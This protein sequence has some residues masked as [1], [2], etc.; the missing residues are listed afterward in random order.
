MINNLLNENEALYNINNALYLNN[1]EPLNEPCSLDTDGTLIL[2]Q[3]VISDNLEYLQYP[4]LEN[5]FNFE[6]PN[7]QNL[8]KYKGVLWHPDLRAYA[9]TKGPHIWDKSLNKYNILGDGLWMQEPS[10]DNKKPSQWQQLSSTPVFLSNVIRDERESYFIE[11]TYYQVDSVDSKW[12][13]A[14]IG[15]DQLQD[16]GSGQIWKELARRGLIFSNKKATQKFRQMIAQYYSAAQGNPSKL[17]SMGRARPGW[18]EINLDG[19]QTLIYISA[20]FST[21]NNNNNIKYTGPNSMPWS[22]NGIE[23]DYLNRFTNMLVKNPIIAL[24][25]GFNA[26]GLL[27]YHMP[28]L[29]HNPIWALLGDSSIGKTLAA[30]TALSMRG[31][32]A[33]YLRNMDA[34]DNALK[35]R[36]RSF[37]HTGGAID[38]IGSGGDKNVKEKLANIYQWASGNARGRVRLNALT[39]EFDEKMENDRY[40]YTLILTGEEAFV[41]MSS[42]NAGNKVR[43]AQVIFNK[44]N[45]LWHSISKK[46]EAEEWRAFISKN[47]GFLYP[48]MIESIASDLEKY[49]TTYESFSKL[50]NSTTKSQQQGRKSNAWA[51]AMTGVQLLADTLA[52]YGF[53]D[54]AIKLVLDHA[55]RLMLLEMDNMPIENENDKFMDFLEGLPAYYKSDLYLY[56]NNK[57]VYEPNGNPKGSLSILQNNLKGLTLHYELSIINAHMESMCVGKIDK[58]R[59]LRWAKEHDILVISE[60]KTSSGIIQRNTCKVTIK[61]SRNVCY[62]FIWSQQIIDD[63]EF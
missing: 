30:E 44:D 17:I 5:T 27:I 54:D 33:T 2:H 39:G 20:G 12:Q 35:S 14:I 7:T 1:E 6:E 11:L 3:L 50:L 26:A 37:N 47:N 60:E 43:L 28:Q 55:K 9:A 62:K 49:I 57:L 23:L 56:E 41:D 63:L 58:T 15:L 4:K 16:E 10:S 48:K 51:L 40:Y 59:F 32:A 38:E 46:E 61:K 45:P 13:K 21:C 31:Q 36:M 18:H 22:R 34:T 52:P 29:D 8:Y 53:S 42:A 25:C 19:E 24:I